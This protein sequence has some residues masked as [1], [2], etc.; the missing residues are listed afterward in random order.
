MF[1]HMDISGY[2]YRGV[3][4]LSTE[5]LTDSENTCANGRRKITGR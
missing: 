4:A 1:E 3:V 2:I 5:K